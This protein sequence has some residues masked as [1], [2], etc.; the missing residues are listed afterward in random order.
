MTDAR[1]D[2]LGG[3]RTDRARAALDVATEL[4]R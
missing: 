4:I 1:H 2:H 3:S